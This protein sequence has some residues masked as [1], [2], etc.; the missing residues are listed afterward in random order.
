MAVAIA[1]PAGLVV[2]TA[3][4]ARAIPIFAQ[5]YALHCTACHSVLP[6]LNAFGN[7]FRRRG[8]RLPITKHGTTIFAIRYQM[9]YS[10]NPPAGSNR[11]TPGGIVL[12]NEDFGNI[13][14]FMHYSLGAQGG[15]GGLYL[16]FLTNYNART[17]SEYRFG[18]FELPL[19]QSPGQR[20]DD[21]QGYGY[22]G[23]HVGLNDLPLSSP[24]WGVWAERQIGGLRADFTV[25]LSEFKGAAYGGKPVP[26]GESTTPAIPE[27]GLW[28]DQTMVQHKT[29]E[30]DAG[31]EA[32]NG[33]RHI[34]LTGSAPFNDPYQRYGLLAHASLWKFDLQT[35]Q[36]WGAD[37]N[38]DGSGSLLRSSG[39]YA[40]FKFYPI[41]HAYVG[42]RY[43]A[44]A[45]PAV[46]RD[47]TYY[48]AGMIGPVRLLVQDVAPIAAPGQKPTLG[49]AMTIA[50]PGPL[51]Y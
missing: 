12:G 23:A 11:W 8:Y 41:D 38:A 45:N 15:P 21:L 50:F 49:G 48:A 36:W 37:H 25:A 51:K 39:G 33:S 42:V 20:L 2:A 26:T 34:L 5:R 6:E 27:T 32:L 29:F 1:A 47:F 46:T 30:F 3:A 13:S 35:E 10:E 17:N 9:S 7:S 24:R 40:R 18:L 14:L 31:G 4:P 22:Y 43:D 44:Q 19:L 28:L 16:G